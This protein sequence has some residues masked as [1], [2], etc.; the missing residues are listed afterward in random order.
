VRAATA[1]L[2]RDWGCEVR[3]A[4]SA[5]QALAAAAGWTPDFVLADHQLGAGAPGTE[6]VQRLRAETGAELA[7]AILTGDS[8]GPGLAAIRAAGFAVLRKPVRP[9]AL[10]A[11]LAAPRRGDGA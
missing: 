2:L 6:L 11:L 10:R 5:E 9:A 8:E 1:E 4:A 3:E 7:A